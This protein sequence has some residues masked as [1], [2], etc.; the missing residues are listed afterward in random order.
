[1]SNKEGSGQWGDVGFPVGELMQWGH[2]AVGP[3]LVLER[4][5]SK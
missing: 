4:Y 3:G 5:W 1:M 2:E